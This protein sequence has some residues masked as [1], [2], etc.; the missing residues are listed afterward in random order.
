MDAE[1]VIP[2]QTRFVLIIRVV[3]TGV[4]VAVIVVCFL[5]S[6]ERQPHVELAPPQ[7]ALG[8]PSVPMASGAMLTENRAVSSRI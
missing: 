3:A 2:R 8:L 4:L 5:A 7:V 6:E 1:H